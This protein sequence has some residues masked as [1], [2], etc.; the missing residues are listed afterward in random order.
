MA[1]RACTTAKKIKIKTKIKIKI[2]I[3]IKLIRPYHILFEFGVGREEIFRISKFLPPNSE[4][5]HF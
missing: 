4:A 1:L 2:K 3:K 5:L